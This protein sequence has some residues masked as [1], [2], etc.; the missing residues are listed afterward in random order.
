MTTKPSYIKDKQRINIF[1]L[2]GF[3]DTSGAQTEVKMP[4]YSKI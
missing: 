2:P 1:D 4:Q 3:G